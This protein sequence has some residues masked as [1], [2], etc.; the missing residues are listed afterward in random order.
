MK[1]WEKN[2]KRMTKVKPFINKYNRDGKI[3]H[4]KNMVAKNLRKIM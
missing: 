4:Q 3:F 2:T 1:K